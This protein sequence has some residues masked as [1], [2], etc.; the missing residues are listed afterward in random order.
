M[1]LLDYNVLFSWQT[2]RISKQFVGKQWELII[3]VLYQG[4]NIKYKNINHEILNIRTGV[5]FFV[6]LIP[7][8]NQTTHPGKLV[9]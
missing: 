9:Q 5:I 7:P 6:Y 2:W 1:P 8:E 4:V 3:Y